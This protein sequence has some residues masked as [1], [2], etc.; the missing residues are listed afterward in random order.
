LRLPAHLRLP[1]DFGLPE[2]K[3]EDGNE[4]NEGL[5]L[6]GPGD[7]VEKTVLVLNRWLF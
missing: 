5:E 6:G 2:D 4:E 3:G 1:A 7:R